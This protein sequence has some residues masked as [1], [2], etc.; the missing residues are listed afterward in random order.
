MLLRIS[1]VDRTWSTTRRA[2]QRR[3]RAAEHP[4]RHH[5]RRDGGRTPQ[6]EQLAAR[7][8][9]LDPRALRACRRP[10]TSWARERAALLGGSALWVAR[11]HVDHHAGSGVVE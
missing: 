3:Q 9:A 8:V 7:G 11:F 4:R 6:T 2:Q 5:E 10:P 1:A